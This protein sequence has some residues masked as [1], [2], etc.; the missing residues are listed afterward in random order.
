MNFSNSIKFSFLFILLGLFHNQ[1]SAQ[2]KVKFGLRAGGNLSTVFGPSEKD[3]LGTDLENYQLK[4]KIGVAA[5]VKYPITDKVGLSAEVGFVQRGGYYSFESNNSYLKLPEFS[6]SPAINY[7]GFKKRLGINLINSYVEIPVLFYYQ[8]VKDRLELELGASV[9]FLVSSQGLGT[10]KYGEEAD[11]EAGNTDDFIEI[12]LSYNYLKDE[13]GELTDGGTIKDVTLNGSTR[14]YPSTTNAYYLFDGNKTNN[15]YNTVDVGAQLGISYFFTPG[16]RV[17]ARAYFGLLDITNSTYDVSQQT[18][19]LDNN[20]IPQTDDF[21]RNFG[22]Q[23][24][25]GLQF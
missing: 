8:P 22:V 5:I 9:G 21:D 15:L 16:L 4:L 19:D 13:V 18:L 17:G 3:A 12:N 6:T 25:V 2:R 20:Y 7:Q 10:L 14:R 11:I 23:F 24:F 1:T